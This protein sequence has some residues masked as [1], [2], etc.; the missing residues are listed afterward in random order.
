MRRMLD[1]KEVGGSPYP[2]MHAYRIVFNDSFHYI[3]YTSKDYGWTI[4]KP[5]IIGQFE[6]NNKYAELLSAGCHSAGGVY[7][8]DS[9]AIIVNYFKIISPNNYTVYGYN[10]ETKESTEVSAKVHTRYIYQLS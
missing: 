4:G 6:T 3:A 7:T 1:P 10:L 5:V 2:A 9:G 8:S